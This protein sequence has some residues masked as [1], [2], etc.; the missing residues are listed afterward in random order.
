MKTIIRRGGDYYKPPQVIIPKIY[1]FDELSPLER[2][3]EAVDTFST[4][5]L[6]FIDEIWSRSNFEDSRIYYAL[7]ELEESKNVENIKNKDLLNLDVTAIYTMFCYLLTDVKYIYF[8]ENYGMFEIIIDLANR[9]KMMYNTIP[10]IVILLNRILNESII[11]VEVYEKGLNYMN[12]KYYQNENMH[13]VLNKI[14][15][16][17][18]KVSLEN[19]KNAI[20]ELE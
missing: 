16:N 17:S 7:K 3:K 8:G 18:V 5:Y 10:A 15:R 9:L 14:G 4:M 11:G 19:F 6:R 20:L 12:Q 1:I 2:V 13:R